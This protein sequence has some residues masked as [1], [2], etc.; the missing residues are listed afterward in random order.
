MKIGVIGYGCIGSVHVENASDLGHSVLVHDPAMPS[1]SSLNEV[2]SKSDAV[3]IASPSDTHGAMMAICAEADKPML[4]EKPIATMVGYDLAKAVVDAGHLVMV[5][6]NMRYHPVLNEVQRILPELGNLYLADFD[7]LQKKENPV[8]HVALN[9]GAHEVD[10]AMFLLGQCRLEKVKEI[11]RGKVKFCL[12]YPSRPGLSSLVTLDYS[13]ES[14]TRAINIIGSTGYII[15]DF[16]RW[17]VSAS[18]LDF[19]EVIACAGRHSDTY[20][21]EL[22]EFINRVEGGDSDGIGAT[23][24]DGIRCLDVLLDVIGGGRK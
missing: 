6:N 20:V 17:I 13:S 12:K 4:V 19:H 10:M 5:G 1:G 15:A 2:V 14:D 24:Q 3:I 9:W 18:G 16:E 21:A 8:D 7:L 11:E 22:K 23:G